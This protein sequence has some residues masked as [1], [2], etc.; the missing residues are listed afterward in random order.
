[1]RKRLLAGIAV[2]AVLLGFSSCGVFSRSGKTPASMPGQWQASPIVID[3]DSK[4]WP[5]P[6]P[7]YDAKAMVAYATSNDGKNLYISMQSGDEL[8]Q[9]KILKQGLTVSIDTTGRKEAQLHINFPMPSDND[10]IEVAKQEEGMN[11]SMGMPRGKK[12]EQKL[13]TAAKNANQ[14]SLEG[15]AGCSGGY[16]STQTNACGIKV[17]MRM[18]EFKELV[19]EAVVPLKAIYHKDSITAA[20]AGK[21][22]SVCF[23][24]KAFK[25]TGIKNA[26]NSGPSMANTMGGGAGMNSAMRNGGG[27]NRGGGARTNTDNPMQHLYD[28]TKTWKQ[29]GIAWKP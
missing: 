21:P 17:M 20:D 2:G 4:D 23:A 19:W 16:A 10:I 18:D 6:Y 7:K 13:A 26:D 29:F 9:M 12:L 15:F 25:P 11:R 24:V 22:I 5:S 1:M 8:T 3:G 28:N 14:L 27:L